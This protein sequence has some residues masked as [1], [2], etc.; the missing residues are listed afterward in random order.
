MVQEVIPY[1]REI[2][3]LLILAAIVGAGWA[4]WEFRDRSAD[5]EA[6]E[7]RAHAEKV[8]GDFAKAEAELQAKYR[9]AERARTEAVAR[10]SKQYAKGREDAQD[11]A[12]AV[13]AD[14][15]AGNVRLRQHWQGAVA[16]CGVSRDSAVALAAERYA[17]LREQGA[18]DLV[19]LGAE[20]DAQVRALQEAYEAM[21]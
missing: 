13:V 11:K 15:R 4:G 16:T 10:A 14:L 8:I 5:I 19:R 12:D 21:R 18:A 2:G 1:A 9:K 7:A 3:A 6:A 17:E 20:A